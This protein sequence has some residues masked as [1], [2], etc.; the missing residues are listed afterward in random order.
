MGKE[1]KVRPGKSGGNIKTSPKDDK[2]RVKE[3]AYIFSSVHYKK[4]VEA[5]IDVD[6][7]VM[8]CM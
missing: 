3:G 8:W 5:A 7:K 1:Q 6:R 4:I 2:Q